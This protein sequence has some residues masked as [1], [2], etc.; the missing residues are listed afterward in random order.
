MTYQLYEVT[1]SDKLLLADLRVSA[2]RESLEALDHFYVHPDFQR[3]GLGGDV[4]ERI[5]A[6]S[7]E[8]ELPVRLGALRKSRSNDF[9]LKH[10]FVKTGEGEWDIYYQFSGVEK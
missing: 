4:L 9:Y 5:K 2:M 10:G 3:S 8:R 1:E 7:K 6:D